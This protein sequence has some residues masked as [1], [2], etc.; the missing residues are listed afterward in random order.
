MIDGWN[1]YDDQ[2]ENENNADVDDVDQ[3]EENDDEVDD[4][5]ATSKIVG[6]NVAGTKCLLTG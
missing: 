6:Q 3:D 5:E 2:D 4:D 1:Q